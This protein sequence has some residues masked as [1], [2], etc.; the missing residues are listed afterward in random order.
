MVAL[1]PEGRQSLIGGLEDGNEGAA[2]LA[3]KS[4]A[5]IVP[6]AMTG[7]E[8]QNVYG[9]MKRWKRTPVTCPSASHLCYGKG[10]SKL[11]KDLDHGNAGKPLPNVPKPI[12]K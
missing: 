8:N 11:A 1:A 3:L 5:P 12:A 6:I 7:T 10:K 2:F 9:H 4:G